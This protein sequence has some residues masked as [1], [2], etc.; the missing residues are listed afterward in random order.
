V[1]E[2]AKSYLRIVAPFYGALGFGFV[3]GFAGQGA[4]HAGAPFIAMITR[5]LLATGLSGGA[6]IYLGP[7]LSNIALATVC[8]LVI[9]ALVSY[10][11][12]IKGVIR[13]S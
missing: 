5:M 12:M 2:P 4:G 13:A 3:F 7:S 11:A 9:Y 8:S 10:V 1:L 6:A